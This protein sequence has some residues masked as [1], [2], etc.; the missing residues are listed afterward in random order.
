MKDLQI[1]ILCD[2]YGGLLTEKQRDIVRDYFDC[3][4]SLSEIAEDHGITRQAA[5]DTVRTCE[6]ALRK[7]EDALGFAEKLRRIRQSVAVVN[8]RLAG[9]DCAGAKAAADEL[10]S[11]I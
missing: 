11:Q 5:L 6:N 7:Y 9:G 10:A 3:D 1:S 8:E 4:L 2:I